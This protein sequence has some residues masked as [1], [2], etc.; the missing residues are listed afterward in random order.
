[1]PILGVIASSKL[2]SAPGDFES[3]ATV[4]GT[5]SSGTIVF[6]SIPSTYKHLQIHALFKGTATGTNTQG[7]LIVQFNSD[8]GSNTNYSSHQINGA[9]AGASQ[10]Q[11]VIRTGMAALFDN[12]GFYYNSLCSATNTGSAMATV[13]MDI[14]DYASTSYNKN[15]A[16][17][18]GKD[19]G[20]NDGNSRVQMASGAWASTAAI[21]SITF[22]IQDENF[23]STNFTA[24]SQFALYGIKG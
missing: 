1:M 20:N 4:S 12:A 22:K 13:V 16:F 2:T 11:T 15:S 23:A 5:G 10:V 21:S 8:T 24:T 6:N 19:I 17:L 9:G 14:Y 3:I 18:F 7:N